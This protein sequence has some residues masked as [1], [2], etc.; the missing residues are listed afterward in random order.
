MI[1]ADLTDWRDMEN[2]LALT[3]ERA[4]PHATKAA[5]NNAAF[6]A[7]GKAKGNIDREFTT[8]NTWTKKS[9]IVKKAMGLRIPDQEALVGST[10]EYML[11]QEEGKTIVGGGRHGKPIPT[12]YSA[13][14]EGQRPRTRLPR[15]ANRM[16]RINL[17]RNRRGSTRKIRNMLAVQQ[18][19]SRGNKYVF[20]NTGRKQFI[21]KVIGKK[22][23]KI[24]MVQ[25]LSHRAVTIQ[26]RPWFGPA[27]DHAVRRL[28][29]FYREAFLFQLRRAGV[30]R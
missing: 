30:I 26:P 22:N 20:L 1:E 18:A 25:D 27:V 9:V 10:Q 8:R 19:A 28:P 3:V 4:V 12:G 6:H 15:P 21:A 24:K 29:S 17:R 7:M 13:G 5:I 14:Q 11:H 23:P 16:Q 2:A